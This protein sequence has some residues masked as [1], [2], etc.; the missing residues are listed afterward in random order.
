MMK[1]SNKLLL[2]FL[3][4]ILLS[5]T[6]FLIVV[7]LYDTPA[8]EG[9]GIERTSTISPGTFDRV[10]VKGKF[11]VYLTQGAPN[12]VVIK[13][14]ENL[15]PLVESIVEKN[16]LQISLKKR[17]R[18][19][20]RIKVFVTVKSIK[21]LTISKGTYVETP[22][23]LN[24]DKLEIESSS[25]SY[26]KISLNYKYL[27]VAISSGAE[28]TISGDA[29]TASLEYSSGGSMKAGGLK[30]KKCNVEGSSGGHGEISVSEELDVAVSSGAHLTYEGSPRVTNFDASSGGS[31]NKK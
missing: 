14:D 25:G 2:G 28:L 20:N 24:G 12:K 22:S 17:I 16:A 9:N 18:R 7:K 21:G 6:A 30:T 3:I 29:N 8:I 1:T 4:L 13:G 5:I 10:D 11:D 26:G 23:G 27:N 31:I 19:N 15:I